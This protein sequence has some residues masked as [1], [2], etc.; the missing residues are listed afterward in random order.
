MKILI[1]LLFV[2]ST[3]LDSA[4]NK[5]EN[6]SIKCSGLFY[7]MTM[8]Q[9]EQ[10]KP[11]VDNMSYLSE[12]MSIIA[13]EIYKK[14]GQALTRGQMLYK[15]DVEADKIIVMYKKDIQSTLNLYAKCDKFRENFALIGFRNPNSD[16]AILDKLRI[17]SVYSMDTQKSEIISMILNISFDT[18]D[19]LGIT[20]IVELRNIR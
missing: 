15:R 19:S 17:P 4:E 2:S 12:T 11:F 18:L 10:W 8:P 16:E 20:S 6:F 9:D 13:S 7:L 14:K 1:I 5:V 3:F